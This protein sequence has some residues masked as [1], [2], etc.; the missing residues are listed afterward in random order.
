MGNGGLEQLS[1][2]LFH[3]YFMSDAVTWGNRT[4][5]VIHTHTWVEVLALSLTFWL[6]DPDF[7]SLSSFFCKTGIRISAPRVAVRSN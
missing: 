7:L 4:S 3:A 1:K 2:V 5:F 6:L